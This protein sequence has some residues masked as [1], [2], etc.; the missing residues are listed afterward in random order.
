LPIVPSPLPQYESQHPPRCS[1]NSDER[2]RR[3]QWN[4]AKM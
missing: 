2:L 4:S 3:A 1:F